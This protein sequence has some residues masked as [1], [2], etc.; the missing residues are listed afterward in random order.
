MRQVACDKIFD[1]NDATKPAPKTIKEP[2]AKPAGTNMAKDTDEDVGPSYAK[3]SEGRPS[4]AGD[5]SQDR[6]AMEGR[7]GTSDVGR[8]NEE[9]TNVGREETR[10]GIDE[11]PSGEPEEMVSL[12]SLPSDEPALQGA[13][14]AGL[15][16]EI[17]SVIAGFREEAKIRKYIKSRLRPKPDSI[18]QLNPDE[19]MEV[20]QA[21]FNPDLITV[22][23]KKSNDSPYAFDRIRNIFGDIR[24]I[25][26]RVINLKCLESRS[27]EIAILAER[28]MLKTLRNSEPLSILAAY[29]VVGDLFSPSMDHAEAEACVARQILSN[30]DIQDLTYA[31]FLKISDSHTMHVYALDF[32]LLLDFMLDENQSGKW[33]DK[34]RRWAPDVADRMKKYHGVRYYL[35]SHWH[36][37]TIARLFRVSPSSFN[38][39]ELLNL[40]VSDSLTKV[41]GING[42]M[43]DLGGDH[44]HNL[45]ALAEALE[46][47]D[48]SL[49]VDV[50]L[51]FKGLV[52]KLE[53]FANWAQ[54][55][56]T[57]TKPWEGKIYRGLMNRF[58]ERV[59]KREAESIF[60]QNNPQTP[61][62]STPIE[63]EV[64]PREELPTRD[65]KEEDQLVK[66]MIE[67]VISMLLS[68][69]KGAPELGLAF[70]KELENYDGNQRLK[71]FLK[72]L[73]E[74]KGKDG[75]KELLA[76]LTIIRGVESPD[77]LS[78]EKLKESGIDLEK[79]NTRVFM[80]APEKYGSEFADC[81]NEKIKNV[82]IDEGE[83]FSTD[84][85]YYPLAEVVTLTLFK[86][87]KKY[88]RDRLLHEMKRI[89]I[90]L[91]ELSISDIIEDAEGKAY[92]IFRLLPREKSH[93]D[94]L[95]RYRHITDY[96]DTA[97]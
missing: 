56:Y 42:G 24:W 7:R 17:V 13:Q 23:L 63:I 34:I 19:A 29:N 45:Q 84:S 65:L 15:K 44:W 92:L 49:A 72:R 50:Y 76:N 11:K 22:I 89:G 69:D 59:R 91:A 32:V 37:G 51:P 90:S 86:D 38:N 61:T 18:D 8:E 39:P 6:Y 3:A 4:F 71:M 33:D 46:A 52:D 10:G 53:V 5:E 55:A 41:N 81:V 95:G 68:F 78:Q 1:V 9:P 82:L 94:N 25:V 16:G 97:V 2:P 57:V 28:F 26:R 58:V 64:L 12:P 30:K 85:H 77:A 31:G 79:N 14:V 36:A 88:S 48:A 67:T 40:L 74:L 27:D 93:I 20:L 80:F 47:E 62:I 21:L 54:P 83:S 43:D 87:H 60:F 75:F 73:E 70:H 96:I 66:C 35:N